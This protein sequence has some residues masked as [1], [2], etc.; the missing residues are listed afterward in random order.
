LYHA[1]IN[2]LQDAET[3]STSG[4]RVVSYNF[5]PNDP[6]RY[7][8][9]TAKDRQDL[10]ET[11]E[12][13][14]PDI[15][16]PVAYT[17]N[18]TKFSNYEIHGKTGHI[19]RISKDPLKPNKIHRPT[20]G[21]QVGLCGS[22]SG[23][24][25]SNRT[26][27]RLHVAYMW[28]FK[29]AE[30]RPDQTEVDHIRGHTDNS[31][32]NLRWASPTENRLYI[33]TPQV[34]R[35]TSHR[36]PETMD[37]S[38]LKQFMHTDIWCGYVRLK[39]E[40]AALYVIFNTR[41]KTYRGIGEFG[42]TARMPYP[43]ITIG[44]KKYLVHRVVAAAEGIITYDDFRG[45]VMHLDDDKTNFRPENLARGTHRENQISRHENLL[46]TGRKR[47]RAVMECG[48]TIE[49]DSHTAAANAVGGSFRG[50]SQAIRRK[51]R[52]RGVHWESV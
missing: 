43:T 34:N 8:Y 11:N 23:D 50:I 21:G 42:V 6:R 19:R 5:K 27:V 44:A 31:P 18:S 2:P 14:L 28:T 7:A 17:N 20:S 41:S 29:A 33:F 35:S 45:V 51:C 16:K 40:D 26:N 30:R 15:W 32:Q 4:L 49:F 24:G 13:S 52:N 46:T 37:L 22:Q 48:E 25:C 1:I 36:A 12:L 9:E 39:P 10:V 47:V 3:E 38:G